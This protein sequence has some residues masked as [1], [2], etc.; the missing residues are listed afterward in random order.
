TESALL[1]VLGGALGLLFAGWGID[2]VIGGLTPNN[3]FAD[4]VGIDART[5]AFTLG[6]SLAAAIG[7]GLWPA[8]EASRWDVQ[9][10]LNEGSARATASRRASV[11]RSAFVAVEIALAFALLSGAGV[12]GKSFAG[13]LATPRGF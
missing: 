3:A 2:L 9:A 4:D 13:L 6:C 8:L 7:A 1:A 5:A 10:A 12:L 11:A